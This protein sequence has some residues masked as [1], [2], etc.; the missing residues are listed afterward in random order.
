MPF[1]LKGAPA[2]FQQFMDD[3]FREYLGNFAVIYIDDIAIFSDSDEEHITHLRKIFQTMRENN[4]FAKKSKCFFGQSRAPYLG[5]YISEKGI[6]MDQKKITTML[7]WPEIK[8]LKQLRGF[9]GLTGYYRRYIQDYAKK[10]LSLT[11]LLKEENPFKWTE[12]QEEAK[13]LLIKALTEA[14]ILQPPNEKKPYT[15][16]T[17]ASLLAMGAVLSQEGKPIAFLSKTF[18]EQQKNWTIYDK[19]MWAIIF[20][21]R[22]WECYLLNGH[23]VTIITDNNAITTLTSQKQISLK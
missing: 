18:S 8:T 3:V 16:T 10:A 9:L 7:N 22:Q 5:H 11:K 12:E 4:I 2:T 14:P 21:L 13:Q 6:E 23:K 15:V 19:E 1:G 17:D 20:A